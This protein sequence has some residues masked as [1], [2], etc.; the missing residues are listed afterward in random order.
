MKFFRKVQISTL[1]TK[2][3]SDR[4]GLLFSLS[5][6]CSAPL[7]P[8]TGMTV[9]LPLMDAWLSSVK[10]QIE[11]QSSESAETSLAT[12]YLL[13]LQ[14][15]DVLQQKSQGSAEIMTLKLQTPQGEELIWKLQGG[16][17]QV[18]TYSLELL[19]YNGRYQEVQ[20][21]GYQSYSAAPG[22]VPSGKVYENLE[23][24]IQE[25]HALKS[26]YLKIKVLLLREE[27]ELE[28]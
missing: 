15:L 17:Q 8:L 21:R 14:I 26:D 24:L 18:A 2:P 10:Q 11:A 3:L 7:N 22:P 20:V 27:L 6:G 9:D 28:V 25:L 16:W 13:G 1:L 19:N 5:V 23:P 12:L 4:Q